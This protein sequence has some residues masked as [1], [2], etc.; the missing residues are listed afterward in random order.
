MRSAQD[1]AVF[2]A[3]VRR[4]WE[5]RKAEMGDEGA[6]GASSTRLTPWAAGGRLIGEADAGLGKPDMLL[7]L[8]EQ[9]A[10]KCSPCYL[11]ARTPSFGIDRLDS[12]EHYPAANARPCCSQ[13]NFMKNKAELGAFMR[14]A[15]R[16]RAHTAAWPLPPG[17]EALP[18]WVPHGGA[19]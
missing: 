5:H 7:P 18:L 10:L 6:E 4:I 12:E 17:V 2:I 1:Q 19:Q 13:C 11:C 3:G 8:D 16:V 15:G 14:H 9:L